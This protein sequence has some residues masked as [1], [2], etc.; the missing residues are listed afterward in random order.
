MEKGCNGIELR[1]VSAKRKGHRGIAGFSAT[2]AIFNMVHIL[3][4]VLPSTSSPRPHS[5]LDWTSPYYSACLF[6]TSPR[7][8]FVSVVVSYSLSSSIVRCLLDSSPSLVREIIN[9]SAVCSTPP[10]QK[11][12]KVINCFCA[13]YHPPKVSLVRSTVVRRS[14][15]A[16]PIRALCIC[17][18]PQNALAIWCIPFPRRDVN[19]CARHFGCTREKG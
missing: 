10:Q 16:T 19:Y 15:D 14:R 13:A 2:S 8:A 6:S 12:M 5:S 9:V 4:H 3:R 11:C 7:L 1:K 18:R 17:L